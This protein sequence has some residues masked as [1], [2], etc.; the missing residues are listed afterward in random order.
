MDEFNLQ[1]LAKQNEELKEINSQIDLLMS[2]LTKEKTLTFSGVDVKKIRGK[3]G[4][5]GEQG[6]TGKDGLNGKDGKDGIDGKNPSVDYEKIVTE[7]IRKIPKPKDGITPVIDYSRIASLIEKEVSK[8]PE[9]IDGVDAVVDYDKIVKMVINKM[10]REKKETPEETAEKIEKVG[11]DYDS[12]KNKP[13]V[14]EWIMK[15]RNDIASKTY[16]ISDIPGLQDALDAG[17][18]D[19][20]Q[21]VTDNG[22]TT[23]NTITALSS[24]TFTYSSGKLTNITYANGV[25][26]DFT[27]NVDGTLDEIIITYP[28]RTITKT[29]V[30]SSG[31]LQNINI[32]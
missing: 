24:P 8:I 13:P 1:L 19:T 21:E 15:V 3:Q 20:L 26:K 14:E 2:A 4:E 28:D 9:P 23:T 5:K 11:L 10:P 7:V 17:N 27:Y 31:V 30:W 32:V 29:L 25:E 22:S 6:P 16:D 12:L 18:S